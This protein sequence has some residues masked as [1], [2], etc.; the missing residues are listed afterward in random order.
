MKSEVRDLR[1]HAPAPGFP[2]RGFTLIELMVVIGILISLATLTAISV[3]KVNKD[4]RFSKATSMVMNALETARTLA[5][6]DH[7]PV[8]L[9]FTVKTQR[10]G[11]GTSGGLLSDPIQ[12]QWTRIVGAR[13]RDELVLET[14]RLPINYYNDLFEAHPSFTPVDL[15]EGIKVAGPLMDFD[16]RD[17]MWATQPTFRDSNTNFTD[18]EYGYMVGVLFG[19]D[20]SLLT[21]ITGGG[22]IVNASSGRNVVLDMDQDGDKLTLNSQESIGAGGDY[23]YNF[24][25]EEPYIQLAPFIAVFNDAAMRELYDVNN[26]KGPNHP[27]WSPGNNPCSSY[28]TGRTRMNCD[29]SEYIN[30]FGEKIYFNRY[31]GRAE[32]FKR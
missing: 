17:E 5:L 32:V 23:T 22:G 16:R 7:R 9:V 13:L 1:F 25:G 6:K 4:A 15:P 19:S 26:W 21:R 12:K 11:T 2:R 24:E 10:T 20:G 14:A 30:Q 31:T 18:M 28:G 8:M 27:D 29:E 3:S